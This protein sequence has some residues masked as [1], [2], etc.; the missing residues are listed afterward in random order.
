MN[1]ELQKKI[2]GEYQ[3]GKITDKEGGNKEHAKEGRW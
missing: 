1:K 2:R 3:V